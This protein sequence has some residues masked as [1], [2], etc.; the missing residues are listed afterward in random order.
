MKQIAEPRVCVARKF[1]K[2]GRIA[3]QDAVSKQYGS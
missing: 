2:S 3:F 1:G